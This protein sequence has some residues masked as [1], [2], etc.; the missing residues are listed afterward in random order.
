MCLYNDPQILFA[1]NDH[2]IRWL[3]LNLQIGNDF[4]KRGVFVGII[5]RTNIIHN[6]MCNF[7]TK[8]VALLQRYEN[9]LAAFI[10][11]SIP[12]YNKCEECIKVH[13]LLGLYHSPFV[14]L[15]LCLFA[16]K[17]A[18]FITRTYKRN[19]HTSKWPVNTNIFLE[20]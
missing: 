7:W 4:L 2:K 20:M 19:V 8:I 13:G 10:Q 3:K 1:I 6:L 9:F 17:V 5:I 14:Q 12:P 18:Q 11:W 16:F 15:Y